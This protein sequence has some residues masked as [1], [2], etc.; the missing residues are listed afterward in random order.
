[1]SKG[2][3]IK[4][5]NI[6]HRRKIREREGDLVI[7]PFP[8]FF[9]FQLVCAYV[10]VVF[11]VFILNFSMCVSFY[12]HHEYSHHLVFAFGKVTKFMP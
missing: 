1:M 6:N 5:I 2:R 12:F 9:N 4:I 7:V 11:L 8:F 10:C 3:T